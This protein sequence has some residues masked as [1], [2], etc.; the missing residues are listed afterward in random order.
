LPFLPS[1]A[2]AARLRRR[3]AGEDPFLDQFTLE[4][5][6]S[7]DVAAIMRCLCSK[8]YPITEGGHPRPVQSAILGNSFLG[9]QSPRSLKSRV[10][11]L[12]GD[13]YGLPYA[14]SGKGRI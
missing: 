10:A 12:T 5:G 2:F 7:C 6:Y 1:E 3:Y 4:V 8:T 14:M 9:I 13:R 11:I